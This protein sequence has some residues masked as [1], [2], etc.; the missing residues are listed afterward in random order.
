DVRGKD[1]PQLMDKVYTHNF[2]SLEVGRIRYGMI[3]SDNGT[4]LDDGTVTR[5]AEDNYYVTTGSG[6]ID[7]VEE[8]FKWWAAG[9]G[10][11]VH[12]TNVTPGVAAINVAGP[13]ARDT[14]AKLTDVDLSP[15]GFKYMRSASGQVA[16]VDCLLL[17][18]GFVGE[19]GWEVHF[20]A[21]YG[22]YMWDA[23]LKA[24]K[25][26]GISP[27]GVEAQRILRLEKKHLIPGQDTDMVSN[28]LEAD[29]GWAIR[30]EKEDFIGRSALNKVQEQGLRNKL[31]GFVM[32]NG[33]VPQDGVPVLQDDWPVGK[34]T[35]S[36]YSPTLGRGF[37]LAWV[38]IDLAEEGREIRIRVDGQ[39]VP[40]RVTLNPVYDP[41]GKHLRE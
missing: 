21:E 30:F 26:F 31:V 15:D 20:P 12:F 28:P 33:G 1:A 10:M 37:G 24:G 23:L 35:S 40:A 3:C 7:L 29:M 5:V 27:F 34:V 11:C 25:E 4:I 38:P 13:R 9:T 8:W 32:E 36:R 17:R 41:E 16:G 2:S 6:N 14:L 18:I 19:T 22:E 39:P